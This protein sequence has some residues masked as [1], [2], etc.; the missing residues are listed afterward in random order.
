MQHAV[1]QGPQ[2]ARVGKQRIGR[3]RGRGPQAWQNRHI[4]VGQFFSTSL[5]E[6]KARDFA[7][8]CEGDEK[9]CQQVEMPE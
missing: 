6:E 7:E 1:L 4:A 9:A 3:L 8:Q 2:A 5:K